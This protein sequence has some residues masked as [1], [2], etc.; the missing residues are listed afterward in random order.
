MINVSNICLSFADK[1][2]FKDISIFIKEKSRI[3]IVGINGSGKTTF[4]RSIRDEVYLDKGKIEINPKFSIA[5]LSQESVDMPDMNII[6]FLMDV[7]GVT[8]VQK[9]MNELEKKFANMD[10][11]SI[12]Y[13]QSLREYEDETHKFDILEGYSFDSKIKRVLKGL[14]FKQ[15]DFD[16]KCT[17]F[18]GGWKV[19]IN[20]ASV[21]LKNPDIMLLDE[22]T[23][24]LDS[25]SME[26]LESYLKDYHGT[27]LTISHDRRFLDKTVKKI[28]EFDKGKLF[29][30][31][32]NYSSYETEKKRRKEALKKEYNAQQNEIK[33][34]K[35]FIE[36]FRSKASKAPQVQSRIKMLEKFDVVELD[37]DNRKI[38]ITFPQA[39]K[40]GNE[41]LKLKS[42]SK[43]YVSNQVFSDVNF[44]VYRSERLAVV[45]YNGAGKSTLFRLLSKVEEPTS[46]EIIHGLNV[47][48]A[49]FSQENSENL[50]S[51]NTIIEEIM[52]CGSGE[53]EAR[54]RTILGT[55]LF[56]G[57]DVYKKVSVLS[58][59][60]K[61]RLALLKILL[62]KSNLLVLDEPTNHL[63]NIT[64]DIFQKALLKYEGTIVIVS[65][66]RYFLDKLVGR[67]F[68]IKDGAMEIFEGNYSYYIE[69]RK[70]LDDQEKLN[71]VKIEEEKPSFKSKEQ[72][73]V[74]AAQRNA[75]YKETKVFKD[76][77]LKVEK[78]IED[79]ELRK[80]EIEIALSTQEFSDM[81][82]TVELSREIGEIE[83]NLAYKMM[84]WEEVH[85]KLDEIENSGQW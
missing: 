74:E 24:H 17:E 32:G 61:S 75:Q 80:D 35:D 78:E 73:K 33:R 30:Y 67:V 2:I 59:G 8:A 72:K 39:T 18:S 81:N 66:D 4:L 79:L 11:E 37:R 7:T 62:Q 69:K 12:E 58:G 46:G 38:K 65:H 29:T 3:G 63:D 53:T 47:E 43:S 13:K 10:H 60:E 1:V 77:L 27:I 71:E 28:I 51:D 22:P 49:Y 31:S 56:S 36:R 52:G 57:N 40:S 15:S 83:K 5:Y 68:E 70:E 26:W 76:K 34:I 21:L 55:F 19:R 41:V 25:D 64:K 42:I 54:L 48:P 84:E 14:G 50:S 9:R 6:D 44:T 82:R 85:S 16:K 45:G 23:N 20:L